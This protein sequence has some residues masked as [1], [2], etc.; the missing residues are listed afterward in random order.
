[1]ALTK[2][3]LFVAVLTFGAAAAGPS[4]FQVRLVT[5]TPA[6]DTE[7]MA[8]RSVDGQTVS[9]SVRKSALLDQSA[10]E[11]AV[12]TRDG[13]DRPQIDILLTPQGSA[14]FA[15]ATSQ[16][17]DRQIAIVIDGAVWSD[18]VITA[19][20]TVKVLPVRGDFTEQQAIDL[21][22]KINAAVRRR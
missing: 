21:A 16:M 9:L 18:P 13:R 4:I 19:P 10:V 11:S 15:E 14:R 6:G 22:A 12:V 1:M 17:S 20:L 8:C 5:E 3:A 2:A 7:Q